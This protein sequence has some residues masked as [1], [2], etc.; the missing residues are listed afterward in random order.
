MHCVIIT[1]AVII[2]AR[3]IHCLAR[4]GHEIYIEP[5]KE[6][7]SLRTVNSTRSAYACFIFPTSFF[8]TYDD[9]ISE[10]ETSSDEGFKCKLSARSFLTVFKSLVTI[11]RMV[12]RCEISM[13][14]GEREELTFLFHCCYGITKT[15]NLEYQDCESLQAVFSRDLLPNMITIQPKILTEVA[16]NFLNAQEEISFTVCPQEMTVSNYFDE[17]EDL[18]KV[19]HT[20][21]CL[22]AEEFEK[23]QIGVDT[24][25]TFCL[26]ELKG[27][28]L[29]AD[30]SGQNLDIHFDTGGKPIVFGLN[31][32]S[33]FKANFVLATLID[34]PDTPG[35]QHKKAPSELKQKTSKATKEQSASS[36]LPDKPSTS[37]E[38]DIESCYDDMF[39]DEFGFTEDEV[40]D[41]IVTASETPVV[42]KTLTKNTG[43]EPSDFQDASSR[44]A[45]TS[46]QVKRTG[47]SVK[48]VHRPPHNISSD[49]LQAEM[50]GSMSVDSAGSPG[51]S[52][53]MKKTRKT[54]PFSPTFYHLVSC[55][56]I[57]AFSCILSI[58][59][60]AVRSGQD[61]T[62]R[63]TRQEQTEVS[64]VSD[65]QIPDSI[66]GTPPSKKFKAM[67][68][69]A[70]S[71]KKDPSTIKEPSK[72][73]VLVEDS[74]EESD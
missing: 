6:G 71:E 14:D 54:Q 51:S 37:R 11:E 17:D 20:K 45:G 59:G 21:M 34:L 9:G 58:L 22:V 47:R 64:F 46:S 16:N 15:Y 63:Q 12:D 26:K 2:F 27:I 74:D 68:F 50:P 31:S 35:S 30:T 52:N 7:L 36:S 8:Q 61:K 28:L 69:S 4:I 40:W 67:F 60:I 24:E 56:M 55:Q 23:F 44:K 5:L 41:N 72:S 48:S 18:A 29:F 38:R 39:E 33:N 25:V 62:A 1:D 57:Y 3:A 43:D 32:D 70:I 49:L 73:I 19:I 13:K 66:P 10:D 53:E 42:Q 65:E